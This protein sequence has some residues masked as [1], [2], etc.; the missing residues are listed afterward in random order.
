MLKTRCPSCHLAE[1]EAEN[2]R[3]QDG[4]D[5]LKCQYD[6]EHDKLLRLQERVEKSQAVLVKAKRQHNWETHGYYGGDEAGCLDC[7]RYAGVL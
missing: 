4:Y 6:E 3:L 5:G 2:A 7:Q 1:L